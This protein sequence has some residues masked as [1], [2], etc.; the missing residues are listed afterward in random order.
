MA[1]R[2]FSTVFVPQEDY[3]RSQNLGIWSGEFLEPWV[4]RQTYGGS[5][6]QTPETNENSKAGCDIKGNISSSG[7]KIYH[8]PGG[9]YYD[10]VKITESKGERWF[11]SEEEAVSQGWR[12]SRE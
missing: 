7:E 9:K 12:P 11:C 3:A 1:Y 4:W 8:L 6:V 10:Q 5:N 2:R